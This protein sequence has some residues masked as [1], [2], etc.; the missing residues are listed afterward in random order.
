MPDLRFRVVSTNPRVSSGALVSSVA[1]ELLDDLTEH[2]RAT[3]KMPDLT[4]ELDRQ[5]SVPIDP[6]SAYLVLKLAAGLIAA[7]AL[8]KMG[9]DAY[10]FLKSRIRNGAI[11]RPGDTDKPKV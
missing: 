7:G 10:E 3:S 8:Q 2:L 1:D 9:E 4:I 11:D 5:K 6:V